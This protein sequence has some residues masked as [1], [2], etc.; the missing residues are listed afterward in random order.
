MFPVCIDPKERKTA[1]S[2]NENRNRKKK[3]RKKERSSSTRYLLRG[4]MSQEVASQEVMDMAEQEKKTSAGEGHI[5]MAGS[6]GGVGCCERREED[7]LQTAD[8]AGACD[9]GKSPWCG[10]GLRKQQGQSVRVGSTGRTFSCASVGSC[11]RLSV[12]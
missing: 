9:G 11:E 5:M 3:K 10:L 7:D 8:A 6:W 4:E 2:L 1:S 12:E